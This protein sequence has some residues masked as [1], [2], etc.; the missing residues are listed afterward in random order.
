LREKPLARQDPEK[1]LERAAKAFTDRDANRNLFIDCYELYSPYRN[2]LSN[3]GGSFNAPTR[4]YDSTGQIS[5][6]SF[7]NT[8]VREFTPPFTQWSVLK[9]GPGIPEDKKIA[10]NEQLEKI[11]EIFFSYLNA[12]N[13]AT[14]SSEMYFEWG[15]GTGALWFYEGD[16]VNP[17]NFVASPISEMGIAEGKYGNV[18]FRCRRYNLKGKLLKEMWPK[19]DIPTNLDIASNPEKEV[20]VTEC[21]YYDYEDLLWRYDVVV[22]K[23]CIF[24]TEHNEEICFTPRWLKI[25]GFSNGVGPF[26]MALADV[27]TLN[28]LKEFLLR[29]AALDVSGV[30]TVTSDGALNPNT[31][32]IAPNTFIPV[33][34]NS[35]ENGPTIQRLDTSANFQLQEYIANGLQD[36]IRKTL[37]D[38]RLPAETAQPKTAFEIAQRMREFQTDIGSAFGRGYF[39]YIQPLWKRGLSILAKRGLIDLPKGFTIDNF[40]VQV[41]VVSPIAQTQQAEEVQRFMQSYQMVSMINP[42]LAATAYK[43]EDIPKWLTEMTG[44]PNKLLRSD[45]EATQMQQ[46]VA[47]FVAQ[48]AQAQ[49]GAPQ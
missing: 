8:M 42:A 22:Q 16:E 1:S 39:E 31:L 41:Q 33:E 19:A 15:I 23:E 29:S 44:T 3:A 28:K 43:V 12:S 36:Q 45:A 30:Y 32:N 11:T 49:Q 13:F 17:F 25:P 38:N 26:V 40:F 46:L 24:Y 5:A 9:A 4:Q 6:A 27:K 18:D 48:Q 34:R 14:A 37:L 2:T 10:L 20:E 7:V 21:F 47:Q 35:G